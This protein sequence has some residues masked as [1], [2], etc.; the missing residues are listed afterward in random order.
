MIS[1]IFTRHVFPFF[2]VLFCVWFFLC[3]SCHLVSP[4]VSPVLTDAAE[5]VQSSISTGMPTVAHALAQPPLT[6]KGNT[7]THPQTNAN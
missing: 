4:C 3:V 7:K 6:E 1:L 5:A 2:Y